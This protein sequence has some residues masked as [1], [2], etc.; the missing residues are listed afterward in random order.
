VMYENAAALPFDLC[1]QFTCLAR[2]LI[3]DWLFAP[4]LLLYAQISS[5][6]VAAHRDLPSSRLYLH[7]LSTCPRGDD[8]GHTTTLAAS[9]PFLLLF[10][11]QARAS[12]LESYLRSVAPRMKCNSPRENASPRLG[13]PS[14]PFPFPFFPVFVYS[15]C[16][17]SSYR[18]AKPSHRAV[19]RCAIKTRIPGALSSL[20]P[21]F[22]PI[23]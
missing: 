9:D 19:M 1:L 2:S 5:Y 12:Y 15:S 14:L 3:P 20:L 6:P 16:L 13:N 17:S 10:Y 22:Y 18:D 23:S 21:S 4:S 7:L 8:R 11:L